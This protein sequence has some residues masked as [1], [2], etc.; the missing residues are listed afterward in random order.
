MN[1]KRRGLSKYFSI[2]LF[3]WDLALLNFLYSL[4]FLL[5]QGNLSRFYD[6][7][8]LLLLVFVNIIWVAHSAYFKMYRIVRID[9]I[10]QV[11]G[12]MLKLILIHGGSL[13]LMVTLLKLHEVSRLRLLIFY[14]LAAVLLVLSRV[15]FLRV[16]RSLRRLG[17]NVRNVLI[18]GAN[19]AGVEL[20]GILTRDL[21]M[22]YRVIGYF[23]SHPEYVKNLPFPLLGSVPEIEEYI[24]TQRIDELYVTLHSQDQHIIRLLIDI[25]ERHMIRIK[26]IPDFRLFTKAHKVNIDFYQNMPVLMMRKEPLEN[27]FNRLSKRLF[28]SCFSLFVVLAVFS[29]LFPVLMLLVKCSSP[30]PIFFRQKRS[31]EDNRE[32]SCL[33][34]RTMR[35]NTLSDELQAT[36]NDPRITKIGAFMRKSNLDE[37][38]QFFN[39]LWGSMSVVGPRPHMLLHTE[40]YSALINNYLVRHFAKP[41]ITGWAQ[42]NGFRGETKAI[43][44]MEK[45]VN[46]D[47]WYI[48]NW[49]FL[50]D[51]KIIW[52]T[53]RNMCLGEKNAY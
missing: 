53:A 26:I 14:I 18:V 48:E 31:G 10:E 16:L 51:M 20:A 23:D 33:K 13:M 11:I 41:G 47:I 15:I 32:F 17:Y 4:S 9:R 38:P 44:D 35:V 12:R 5:R 29:W 37:L 7:D 8:S 34:F 39:V 21:S 22:G 6:D 50:L 2:L 52:L 45:R 43:G 28:D 30:G 40:E 24:K 42:V 3:I 27:G 19:E 1:K 36:K 25:A 49:S 46:C